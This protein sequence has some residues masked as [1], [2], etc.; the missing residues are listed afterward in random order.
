VLES[1]DI[2]VADVGIGSVRAEWSAAVLV[3]CIMI[4]AVLAGSDLAGVLDNYTYGD[5]SRL[6]NGRLADWHKPAGA[7][8]RHHQV[9]ILMYSMATAYSNL[10]WFC[11]PFRRQLHISVGSG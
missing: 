10:Y 11:R 2:A 4:V 1:A 9:A 8:C 5:I 3:G 7:V 6:C